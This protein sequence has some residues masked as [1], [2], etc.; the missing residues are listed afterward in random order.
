MLR[1]TWV[2][3]TIGHKAGARGTIRALG[4]HRLN[5]SVQVADTP[6]TRGML[7]RVAF[8]VTVDEPS[9]AKPAEGEG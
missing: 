3:S 5:E 1:V 4:L 7:R 8:L 2:K 6:V 9:G